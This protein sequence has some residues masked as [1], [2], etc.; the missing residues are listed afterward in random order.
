MHG[1]WMLFAYCRSSLDTSYGIQA[2]AELDRTLKQYARYHTSTVCH[3]TVNCIRHFG[4]RNSKHIDRQRSQR[5]KPVGSRTVEW[6]LEFYNHCSQCAVAVCL[7]NFITVEQHL[8]LISV[9]L[10]HD[11]SQE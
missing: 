2:N 3:T 9:V 11:L 5:S 7:L 8:D 6:H 4:H 1:Y 10:M